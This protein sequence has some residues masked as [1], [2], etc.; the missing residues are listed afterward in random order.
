[1]FGCFCKSMWAKTCMVSKVSV[2]PAKRVFRYFCRTAIVGVAAAFG[3]RRLWITSSGVVSFFPMSFWMRADWLASFRSIRKSAKP[4]LRRIWKASEWKVDTW[5]C[6]GLPIRSLSSL[7]DLRVK[8]IMSTWASGYSWTIR[9]IL[10]IRQVL[11]PVPAPALI[12]L[13]PVS[14][15]MAMI[16]SSLKAAALSLMMDPSLMDAANGKFVGLASQLG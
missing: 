7:A 3:Q 5:T 15:E 14:L 9:C 16:C 13:R 6:C 10:A 12:Q 1:M 4:L 11:V 2:L 8:E